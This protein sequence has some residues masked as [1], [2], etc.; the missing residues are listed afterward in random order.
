MTTLSLRR[1]YK[2]TSTSRD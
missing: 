2:D 1:H